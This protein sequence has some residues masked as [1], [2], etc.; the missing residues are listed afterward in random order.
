VSE[1]FSIAGVSSQTIGHEKYVFEPNTTNN[2][3]LVIG[4]TGKPRLRHLRLRDGCDRRV[5]AP[6]ALAS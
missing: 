1:I 3:I 5:A 6:S 4:G 2:T